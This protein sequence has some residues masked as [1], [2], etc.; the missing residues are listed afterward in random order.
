MYKGEFMDIEKMIPKKESS[1]NISLKEQIDYIDKK[2]LEYRQTIDELKEIFNKDIDTTTKNINKI[3]LHIQELQA[4]IKESVENLK[5]YQSEIDTIKANANEAKNI[6]KQINKVFD[7]IKDIQKEIEDYVQGFDELVKNK[8]SKID[9]RATKLE[10]NFKTQMQKQQGFDKKIKKSNLILLSTIA[11]SA[12]IAFI[13]ITNITND[14][15]KVSKK[16][17]LLVNQSKEKIEDLS[18][19]VANLDYAKEAKVKEGFNI[20]SDQIQT[21]KNEIEN[22]KEAL[23]NRKPNY[24]TKYI[25]K[26]GDNNKV[27]VQTRG[28]KREQRANIENVQNKRI[29]FAK[30]NVSLEEQEEMISSSDDILDNVRFCS[31][32]KLKDC[33]KFAFI[34]NKKYFNIGNEIYE[35]QDMF[36]YRIVGRF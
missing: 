18:R 1:K 31:S 4:D 27:V 7:E 23:R 36:K 29:A 19:S 22:L 10:A 2:A 17:V 25:V 20:A 5:K 34:D 12:A 15:N 6:N 11:A 30:Q 35:V 9:E 33:C 32:Y 8:L 13:V 14:L 26:E 16:S 24:I 3:K 28:K 21:L